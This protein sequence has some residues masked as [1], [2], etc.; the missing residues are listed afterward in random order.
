MI[1]NREK[2][3]PAKKIIISTDKCAG[4]SYCKLSCPV[5]AIV[6]Q[7]ALAVVTDLCNDCGACLWVCPVGAISLE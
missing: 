7:D 5:E 4:C 1:M 2:R 3:K 6:V